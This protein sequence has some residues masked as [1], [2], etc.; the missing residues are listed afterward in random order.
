[1]WLLERKAEDCFTPTKPETIEANRVSEQASRA[2]PSGE[3][4]AKKKVILY[5]TVKKAEDYAAYL[6]LLGNRWNISSGT[7]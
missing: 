3:K 2:F 1:V 4:R 7:F 5:V 6:E